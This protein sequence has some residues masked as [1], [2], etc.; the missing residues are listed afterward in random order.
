MQ[1]PTGSQDVQILTNFFDPKNVK[2]GLGQ[3][4][5]KNFAKILPKICQKFQFFRPQKFFSSL[6]NL[7]FLA[8]KYFLPR[9]IF[10]KSRF[11]LNF[12]HFALFRP[13]K[14]SKN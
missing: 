5:D 14:M 6:K 4:I 3:K 12:T 8:K 11:P 7:K 9:L 1:I 13:Q 2:F 10:S